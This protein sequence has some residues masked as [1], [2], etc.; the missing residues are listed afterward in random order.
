MPFADSKLTLLLKDVLNGGARTT[1][2]ICASLE[3]RNAVESIQAHLPLILTLTLPLPLTLTSPSP[4]PS[5]SRSRS[6]S[7]SPSPSP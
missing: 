1:V 5:R 7:P 2:L 4:S 6:R 3:P